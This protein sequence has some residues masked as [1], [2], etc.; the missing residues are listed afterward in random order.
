MSET[1]NRPVHDAPSDAEPAPAGGLLVQAGLVVLAVTFFAMVGFLYYRWVTVREPKAVIEVRVDDRAFEGKKV[2]VTNGRQK[3]VRTFQPAPEGGYFARFL[4]PPGRWAV[5]IDRGDRVFQYN[6]DL[7]P[8][9][10]VRLVPNPA[11]TSATAPATPR[12]PSAS[13]AS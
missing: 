11:P 7:R 13:S 8:Y 9:H 5:D 10:T 12:R 6:A 4:L 2:V 3:L 1:S